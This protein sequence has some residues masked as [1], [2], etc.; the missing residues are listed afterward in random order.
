MRGVDV[1]GLISAAVLMFDERPEILELYRRR[2]RVI[3]VDEFQDINRT[4]YGFLCRLIG[5]GHTAGEPSAPGKSVLVIGDP[6]QA[7]YGFRGGDASLFFRFQN[8][9]QARYFSLSRNYRSTGVIVGAARDLAARNALKSGLRLVPRSPGGDK[10]LVTAYRDQQAEAE[11]VAALIHHLVG[12]VELHTQ[13]SAAGGGRFSFGDI[14]VLARTHRALE[15]CLRALARHNIPAVFR[16]GRSLLSE[17]PY[18]LLVEAFRYLVNREDVV[19]FQNIVT[20]FL[21]GFT[22]EALAAV[23][24]AFREAAGDPEGL[25]A[26]ET[27]RQT[28]SGVE[29]GALEALF[30]FLEFVEAEIEAQGVGK[31]VFLLLE[32]ILGAEPGGGE[33]KIDCQAL[34]EMAAGYGNDLGRFVR[35]V[36]LSRKEADFGYPVERVSCLTFHAAKG[37]EFPV[38]IIAAAEEGITPH[39]KSGA[40]IDE[41]RRLFYVAL[42]RAGDKACIT[43]AGRREFYGQERIQKPSRFIEEIPVEY[44]ERSETK[45]DKRTYSQPAL[46]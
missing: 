18:S 9:Y 38:V 8:D 10:I 15:P 7:V 22:R 28:L 19:A 13:D 14:A 33:A 35:E 30:R 26:A 31:G 6:D 12:G 25:T 11:G 24:S 20:S 34:V 41:E 42:T 2:F 40:D 29:R 45:P 5:P 16:A 39:Q 4:Q 37:L 46:F 21:P 3:A 44:R 17:P 27:V 1:A 36:L 43:H 23:I 32:K